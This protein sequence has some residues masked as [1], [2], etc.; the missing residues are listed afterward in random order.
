M[1]ASRSKSDNLI[2]TLFTWHTAA[3]DHI[4]PDIVLCRRN[5]VGLSHFQL[6]K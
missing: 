1:H 3:H 5:A 2:E 4:I 6:L